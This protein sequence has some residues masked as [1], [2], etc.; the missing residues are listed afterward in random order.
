MHAPWLG[1]R[2]VAFIP[3]INRQVD[4]TPPLD[5]AAQV[6][7]R[8]FYDP[9]PQ[10]GVDRGL[11][12]YIHTISYGKAGLDARVFPMAVSPDADT[13]GVGLRSL[14][15]NHGYTLA[16]VVVPSGGR[17]RGGF[18]WIHASPVNG[19]PNFAR[20]NL[21]ESL[22]TW[23][24]ELLH[25][26]T[27]FGDLYNVEPDMGRYDTMACA[28]GPHPS[29]HTKLDMQWLS[30]TGVPTK[31]GGARSSYNLHALGLLQPPPPGRVAAVRIPSRVSANHFLV[32]ARLGVDPYERSSFAS[33][34]IPGEGVIVY[35]VASRTK[36]YLRT[37]TALAVGQKY[38]AP[39]N[40]G[41]TVQVSSAI[42]GGFTVAIET[43]PHPDC[44]RL[45][46]Q[47]EALEESIEGEEDPFLRRRLLSQLR[48]LQTRASTLG[49][50]R[51]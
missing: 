33:S 2:R 20:V 31:I 44:P 22:G 39:T 46:E 24:M 27:E 17:D 11:R 47:I 38:T 35:E 14:P 30:A 23:A 29:A 15:A 4:Q 45:L 36:V 12:T 13:V 43:R 19:V 10:T 40:E 34:G 16:V 25:I 28:C 42:P 21:M 26:A 5:F 49:C 9:D 41:F 3:V 8:V 37:A 1:T 51:T 32:E 18:A 48:Q 6:E 7:R 50:R